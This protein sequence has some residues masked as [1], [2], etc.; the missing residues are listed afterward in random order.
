MTLVWSSR[1]TRTVKKLARAKPGLLDDLETMLQQLKHDPHHPSLRTHKLGGE[2][3]DC[4]ACFT[5]Y[6]FRVL[7]QFTRHPKTHELEI[8]LLN[9]GTHDEVY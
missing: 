7:F 8:H 5:G 6:D 4:W 1:F 2:L 9:L 3:K